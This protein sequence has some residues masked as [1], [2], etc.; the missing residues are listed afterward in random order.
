MMWANWGIHWAWMGLFWV[1]VLGVIA[2]AAV[3]LAPA[4]TDRGEKAAQRILEER[5]ARGEV[6]DEEY[7]RRR[8]E[9]SR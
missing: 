1:V 2:W 3:R 8:S 9:L 5:Y 4:T 6:D 7:R